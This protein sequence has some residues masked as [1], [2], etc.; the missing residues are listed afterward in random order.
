MPPLK[1]MAKRIARLRS[2]RGWSQQAL[3][4]RA[5]VHRVYV[6]RLE[7]GQQDPRV[8]VL[9][10]ISRALRVKLSDLVE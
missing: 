4:D 8:S 7:L 3:A 1:R 10:R 9:L 6:A 5:G 2:E